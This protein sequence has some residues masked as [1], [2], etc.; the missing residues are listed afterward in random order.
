M[1]SRIAPSSF[2]SIVPAN[3]ISI[4]KSVFSPFA[5]GRLL[6]DTS[7]LLRE[8][9]LRQF[10][11]TRRPIFS[12]VFLLLALAITS[13]AT[14]SSNAWDADGQSAKSDVDAW[15]DWQRAQIEKECLEQANSRL[16]SGNPGPS[17]LVGWERVDKSITQLVENYVAEDVLKLTNDLAQSKLE[18]ER[19][20]AQLTD[21]LVELRSSTANVT[22]TSQEIAAYKNT[23]V[24][25]VSLFGMNNRW[26]WLCA[27]FALGSLAFIAWHSRRHEF[28]KAFNGSTAR[29]LGLARFLRWGV[30][31][32]GLTTLISFLFGDRFFNSLVGKN[33]ASATAIT[34]DRSAEYVDRTKAL[35]TEL[36]A[37]RGKNENLVSE[38]VNRS[39]W[40]SAQTKSAWMGL[41]SELQADWVEARFQEELVKQVKE[42]D[43]ELGDALVK[44]TALDSEVKWLDSLK[45]Y[46]TL[47]LGAGLST[48]CLI[49][50]L[51]LVGNFS[52][53]T[54]RLK[55]LCPQCLGAGKMGL[56]D[57][58]PGTLVCFNELEADGFTDQC[59]FELP[60]IYML[61]PKLCFPALGIPQTGKTHWMAMCFRELTRGNF[62]KGIQFEKVNARGTDE[63]DEI[64][65]A[66]TRDRVGPAA[67]Q[68]ERIRSPVVFNFADSDRWGSTNLL[69]NVFDYSGEMTANSDLSQPI[70]QRALDADGYFFFLDPTQ[71]CDQQSESISRFRQDVRQVKKVAGGSALHVP[72]A[73]CL[74]KIDLLMTSPSNPDENAIREF[75]AQLHKIDQDFAPYTMRNIHA[76]SELVKEIR[77]LIWPGWQIEQELESLFGGRLLFFPM[78]PVGITEDFDSPMTGR[79]LEPVG[80]I[81]P[82]LWLLQMNG[83]QVLP[84]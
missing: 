65:R 15:A 67:T 40:N 21:K 5:D 46:L 23:S 6:V 58:K 26:L 1:R 63:L 74:T 32:L 61:L 60:Q 31:V 83:F 73:L 43:T 45:R 50:G 76:K 19:N 38:W 20:I 52:R 55:E 35:N 69:L 48:A 42:A 54:Q 72:V 25:L 78:T 62:P 44:R 29:Q 22:R 3:P 81:E 84:E 66:I 13:I 34:A 18:N 9:S 10:T 51:M 11:L 16:T 27:L 14:A 80:V 33:P 64:A 57:S 56:S 49:V 4:E 28:R 71:D 36:T 24:Q 17:Q 39:G 47:G 82:M 70:R 53:R 8:S 75:Y 7:A 41:Q 77:E 2:A 79:A 37:L 59:A 68:V 12:M 30:L